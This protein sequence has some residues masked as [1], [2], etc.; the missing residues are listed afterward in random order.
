[1]SDQPHQPDQ[2][3]HAQH[4]NEWWRWARLLV[5]VLSVFVICCTIAWAAISMF[6]G[7][8]TVGGDADAGPT[9]TAVQPQDPQQSPWPMVVHNSFGE[10]TIDRQPNRAVALGLPSADALVALGITPAGIPDMTGK[11]TNGAAIT[12]W[13]DNSLSIQKPDLL[14]EVDGS[15]PYDKISDLKP[16]VI[17][18]VGVPLHEDQYRTL[19]RIAP[20]VAHPNKTAQTGWRETTR[21][22]G[23]VMGKQKQADKLIRDTEDKLTAARDNH[24]EFAGKTAA[25]TSVGNAD[26]LRVYFDRDP[27]VQLLAALGFSPIA[28]PG[29]SP[30]P[31]APA[32]G[33]E[34]APEIS[35]QAPASSSPPVTTTV[36][37]AD[38]SAGIVAGHT[39]IDPPYSVLL[40]FDQL[41]G[42]SPDC[43]LTW[44]SNDEM[45]GHTENNPFFTALP[46]VARGCFIA[47]QDPD[48]IVAL[49]HPS[50]LTI[51]WLMDNLVPRISKAVTTGG[52]S[53]PTATTAMPSLQATITS[54]ADTP[55]PPAP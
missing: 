3:L 7:V 18:A 24:P 46:P 34:P 19:S 32:E 5:R 51:A 17:F 28:E 38:T 49:E 13:M 37:V 16:D 21:I 50:V 11:T 25:F 52:G 8:V 1:M 39:D 10:V 55:R 45:R 36:E 53:Q 20:T 27:T 47:F 9:P 41:G 33:N 43:L 35:G 23:A 14:Q 22:I 12:P 2:P 44:F 48:T 15:L 4:N 26:G 42:M 29:P 40:P 31:H 6:G 30:Y 54:T